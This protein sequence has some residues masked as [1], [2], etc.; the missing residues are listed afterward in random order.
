M[1]SREETA[2]KGLAPTKRFLVIDSDGMLA[3]GSSDEVLHLDQERAE[4]MAESFAARH[5]GHH[6]YVAE[7]IVGVYKELPPP[8]CQWWRK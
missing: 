1:M 6:Y 5:A 8:V 3:T 2:M 4:A 7:I